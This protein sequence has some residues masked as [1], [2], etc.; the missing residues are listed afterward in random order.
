ML[1]SSGIKDQIRRV[2][3]G[4]ASRSGRLFGHLVAVGNVE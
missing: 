1:P 4:H 3:G 2:G